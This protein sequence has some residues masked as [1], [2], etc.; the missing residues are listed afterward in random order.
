MK[1]YGLNE[2]LASQLLSSDFTEL[3]ERI[4]QETH[5]PSSFS[6]ATLVETMKSLKRQSFD[7]SNLSDSI[8]FQIFIALDSGNM[9]KEAMPDILA[10]LTRNPGNT[11]HDGLKA[12]G[13]GTVSREELEIAVGKAIEDN[14]EMIRERRIGALGPLMGIL[15]KEFRGRVDAKILNDMLRKH[16]ERIQ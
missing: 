10:W 13:F 2:T 15:M 9:A 14:R 6:A 7:V 1:E 3:F 4:Q 5:I 11:V 12:L 8:I 16:I